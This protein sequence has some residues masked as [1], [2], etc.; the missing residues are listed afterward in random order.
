[1]DYRSL[2]VKYI[3]YVGY[4]EGANYLDDCAQS[5]S[6][7]EAGITGDEFS[8]L[9]RLSREPLPE[10]TSVEDERPPRCIFCGKDFATE[11]EFD[12]HYA[13]AQR[14]HTHDF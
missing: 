4:C 8:E 1:M 3:R 6:Q 14:R 2:L 9:K 7:D 13:E 10:S 11:A 5:H 12:A